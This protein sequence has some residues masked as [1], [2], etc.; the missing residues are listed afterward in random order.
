MG[1]LKNFTISTS[2]LMT[3]VLSAQ[4]HDVTDTRS[5]YSASLVMAG[6]ASYSVKKMSLNFIPAS[7]LSG[8]VST[9]YA[10]QQISSAIISQ[11]ASG[12]ATS[13][14]PDLVAMFQSTGIP[15]IAVAYTI[16]DIA[17]TITSAD[18]TQSR[19]YFVYAPVAGTYSFDVWVPGDFDQPCSMIK[20]FSFDENGTETLRSNYDQV[21]V[22]DRIIHRQVT[23]P[24]GLCHINV[25]VGSGTLKFH[26]AGYLQS[27]MLDST[28]TVQW[29]QPNVPVT[30][31]QVGLLNYLPVVGNSTTFYSQTSIPP[32]PPSILDGAVVY[33][34]IHPIPAVFPADATNSG[35][36]IQ[37]YG[38]PTDEDLQQL[39][40]WP[41]LN[42]K[43]TQVGSEEATGNGGSWN[44]SRLPDYT[45]YYTVRAIYHPY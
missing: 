4:I 17:L 36:S 8:G 42:M 35:T 10:T 28:S 18:N 14:A 29:N 25:S 19:N 27:A 11:S 38:E 21:A 26:T 33:S 39:G 37:I 2:L 43:A 6:D 23:L 5:S 3:S 24:K 20:I 31:T 7:Q 40:S 16:V 9:Q 1:F 30:I 32:T 12:A 22:S 13:I 44:L 41:Y 34:N 15:Y 45:T